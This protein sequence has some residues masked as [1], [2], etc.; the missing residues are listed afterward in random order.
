MPG[1]ISFLTLDKKGR[2]TLP[3]EVRS[4]LDVG[5]GDLILLERTERGTFELTPATLIPNDQLWF[6]HPEVQ[7][8]VNRAERDFAAGRSTRTETPEEAQELLDS[9]KEQPHLRPPEAG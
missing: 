7:A 4:A 5:A 8:R 2:A 1:A 9:L 3:E 6:H